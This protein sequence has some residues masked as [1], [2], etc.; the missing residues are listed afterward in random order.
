MDTRYRVYHGIQI[1]AICESRDEVQDWL[2]RFPDASAEQLVDNFNATDEDMWNAS[3][4]FAKNG[5]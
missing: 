5:Y 1:L 2:D 4:H 3:Q